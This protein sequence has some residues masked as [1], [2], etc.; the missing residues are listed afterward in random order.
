MRDEKQRRS[1]N[2]VLIC[3]ACMLLYKLVSIPDENWEIFTRRHTTGLVYAHH[4]RLRLVEEEQADQLRV[5]R[6]NERWKNW[7]IRTNREFKEG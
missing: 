2:V 4:I 5:E 7:T 3:T 6:R 1:R